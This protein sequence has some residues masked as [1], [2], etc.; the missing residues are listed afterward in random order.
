[1][2]GLPRAR[3]QSIPVVTGSGWVLDALTESGFGAHVL[4]SSRSFDLRFLSG[5]TRLVRMHRV[6]LIHTHLLGAS[7]YGCL[8]GFLASTPVVCTFHGTGDVGAKG[9]LRWAKFRIL[10]RLA[11]RV[12]FVSESLRRSCSM[13]GFRPTLTSIIRNGID[14]VAFAPGTDSSLREE[15][16]VRPGEVLVGAIGNLRPA[17]QYDLLLRAAALLRE[18]SLRYR[19][20]VVGDPEPSLLRELLVLRDQ[21]QLADTVSFAGFREDVARVLRN[22]DIYV[23]SSRS[24]GFSLATVQALASGV[25]VVATRCGGPEEIITDG[26]DGVLVAANDAQALADGIH[27]VIEGPELRRRLVKAGRLKVQEEFTIAHML[28]QYGRL[29][30]DCLAEVP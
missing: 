30:E 22:L 4:E 12:V 15:L 13:M 5:L 17:K 6:D 8:A 10:E 23:L 9:G 1:M 28:S 11:C 27:S 19:F 29:Y 3:W 26:V 16:G 18:H 2:R 7:V 24:E 14:P 25:P 21:L 20:V